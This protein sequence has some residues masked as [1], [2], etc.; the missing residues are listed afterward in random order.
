MRWC[1][2][3]VLWFPLAAAGDAPADILKKEIAQFQGSW[4]ALSIQHVDGRQGSDDELQTTRLT[5]SGTTF[6]LAG[7]NY[8]ISGTFTVDPTKSP[9]T[10]DVTLKGED[11]RVTRILGIYQI[12]GATRKSCFALQGEERPT[13]FASRK[14]QFGL[15]WKRSAAPK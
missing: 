13:Q 9:K 8:S 7:K 15:E 3:L 1:S 11:G 2:L 12:Q 4:Q 10:I 6:I 5:V 14:G